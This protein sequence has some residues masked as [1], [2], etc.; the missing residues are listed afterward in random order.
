[1]KYSVPNESISVGPVI[2]NHQLRGESSNWS[3]R[4]PVLTR[5]VGW[6]GVGNEEGTRCYLTMKYQGLLLH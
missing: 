2:N 5:L 6:G 3:K 1:M 4:L